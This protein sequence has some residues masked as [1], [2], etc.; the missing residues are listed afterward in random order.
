MR[1]RARHTGADPNAKQ[2]GSKDDGSSG[3]TQQAQSRLKKKKK[4]ASFGGSF[5][6]IKYFL[7]LLAIPFIVNYAALSKEAR[8]LVPKG[9]HTTFNFKVNKVSV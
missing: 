1:P 4:K 6:A 3:E 9:E 7:L 5:R 8:E 2:H